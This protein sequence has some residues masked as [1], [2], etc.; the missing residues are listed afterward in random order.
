MRRTFP[1]LRLS[2]EAAGQLQHDHQR[3]IQKLHALELEH[4]EFVRQ[5]RALIGAS[6]LWQLQTATRNAVLLDAL[7]KEAKV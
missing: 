7:K 6:A 4:A 2:P 5:V 3:A 1:L